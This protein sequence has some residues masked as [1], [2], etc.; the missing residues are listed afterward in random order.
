MCRSRYLLTLAFL[1]SGA[2]R[3]R[4]SATP[5][6][7]VKCAI[8][9]LRDGG[10]LRTELLFDTVEVKP[11]FVCHQV[12]GKTQMSKPTGTTDTVKI[13]FRVLGKVEVD[14]DVDGLDIDSASEEVRTDEVPTHPVAEVVED[15]VTV[16]L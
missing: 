8:D 4:I 1:G 3:N 2:R 13:C 10:N 14:D 16:R 5:R 6:S 15:T 9:V 12:N 11:V 7:D